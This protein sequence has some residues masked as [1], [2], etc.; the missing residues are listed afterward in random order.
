[1]RLLVPAWAPPGGA[2]WVRHAGLSQPAAQMGF[3]LVQ[4]QVAGESPAGGPRVPSAGS[5]WVGGS[6]VTKSCL[7]LATP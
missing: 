5:W 6:V 7:T 4:E 2:A 1:M 3:I